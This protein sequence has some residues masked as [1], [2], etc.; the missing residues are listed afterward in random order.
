MACGSPVNLFLVWACSK[1]ALMETLFSR[2]VVN[3]SFVVTCA[4]E[5]TMT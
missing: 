1:N 4:K 3:T 2:T 5:L